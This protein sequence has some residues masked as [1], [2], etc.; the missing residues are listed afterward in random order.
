M[1]SKIQN[2]VRII[3]PIFAIVVLLVSGAQWRIEAAEDEY[4]IRWEIDRLSAPNLPF[5]D[6]TLNVAVG[7]ANGIR[8]NDLDGNE[9]E[10]EYDEQNGIVS[11]TTDGDAVELAFFTETAGNQLVGSFAPATLKYNRQWAWSHGFDDNFNLEG[12]ISQFEERDWRG[13]L[14]LIGEPIIRPG[15]QINLLTTSEIQAFLADGWSLGNHSFDYYECEPRPGE[16]EQNIIDGQEVLDNL[17]ERSG[18]PDYTVISFAAPCFLDQFHSAILDVRENPEI[19][20][21]VNESGGRFPLLVDNNAIDLFV[22]DIQVF[23]YNPDLPIGRDATIDGDTLEEA[24]RRIDWIARNA[25]ATHHIWYNSLSH[26][27]N[28]ALENEGTESRVGSLVEY[29]YRNYGP[30]GT[31]EVW[32]A[33]SDQVVSYVTLRDTV[34]FEV[35]RAVRNSE[36]IDPSLIREVEQNN[37]GQ[38]ESVG[39][40]PT[41]IRPEDTPIPIVAEAIAVEVAT[42]VPTEEVSEVA[43]DD[44]EVTEPEP[45][46][47]EVAQVDW[48]QLAADTSET[49]LTGPQ[50]DDS[51]GG[52]SNLL[53]GI[54]LSAVCVVTLLIVG[55]LFFVF[56]RMRSQN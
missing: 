44:T 51:A 6:I 10:F 1:N 21:R 16:Y 19:S 8:V 27:E 7:E 5:Q 26:G 2:F 24:I 17:I 56:R 9:L 31:N 20:L 38:L 46:T 47:D 36:S 49:E 34:Q 3:I 22:E 28:E 43:S 14:F 48:E 35:V 53:M 42:A 37:V 54:I 39:F 32:V 52:I 13:T 30:L 11:I 4:L 29:I 55:A 12:P 33:P 40:L 25:D 41:R 15:G 50:T 23:A 18:R 45:S